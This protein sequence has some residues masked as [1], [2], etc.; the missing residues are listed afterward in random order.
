MKQLRLVILALAAV[1]SFGA[2]AQERIDTVRART[3]VLNCWQRSKRLTQNS[4]VLK[5]LNLERYYRKNSRI[6]DFV[7]NFAV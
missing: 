6:R 3:N 7:H 5:L 2:T 4:F 1:V